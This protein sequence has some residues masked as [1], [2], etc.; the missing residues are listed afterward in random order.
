MLHV[1]GLIPECVLACCFK[2]AD[3]LKAAPH[4][5]HLK[6]RG[7][8]LP[9]LTSDRTNNCECIGCLWNTPETQIDSGEIHCICRSDRILPDSVTSNGSANTTTGGSTVFASLTLFVFSCSLSG[10]FLDFEERWW[11]CKWTL[12]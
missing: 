7:G 10:L 6:G 12:K 11:A 3:F 5:K 1:Y 8:L 9:V 4:C 2:W